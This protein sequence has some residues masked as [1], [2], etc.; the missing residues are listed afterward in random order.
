MGTDPLERLGSRR[1]IVITT[2]VVAVG[3]F[4]GSAT[5]DVP[6]ALPGIALRSP[7]LL[8]VERSLLVG[9]A[10]AGA[11]IFLLRGWEGYFP[12][13][14]STSGAEYAASREAQNE[15]DIG[16]GLVQMEKEH[17][18]LA[19]SLLEAVQVLEHRLDR[20]DQENDWT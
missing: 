2:A 3:A 18:A 17:L 12:L 6:S 10:V 20:L 16:E 19:A 15:D 8:H 14:L 1:L 4:L 5:S 7:V 9:A 11:L 13:K